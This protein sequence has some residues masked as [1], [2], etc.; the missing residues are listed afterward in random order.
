[1]VKLSRVE[2]VL[3]S[4][5]EVAREVVGRIDRIEG[6]RYEGSRSGHLRE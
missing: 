3:D 4:P 5:E 2:S 1:M 6:R